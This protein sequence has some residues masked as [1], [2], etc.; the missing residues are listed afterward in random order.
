MHEVNLITKDNW[1]E[2]YDDVYIETIFLD[3]NIWYSG[4]ME[5]WFSGTEYFIITNFNKIKHAV[6]IP[7]KCSTTNFPINLLNNMKQ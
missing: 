2:I 6:Y 5:V 3:K 4:G 1:V 7:M